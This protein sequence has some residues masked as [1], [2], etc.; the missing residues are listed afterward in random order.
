[1]AS[2]LRL[3][4]R[5][6]TPPV[7]PPPS[8]SISAAQLVLDTMA[9]QEQLAEVAS[10]SRTAQKLSLTDG[11]HCHGIDDRI[12]CLNEFAD[13]LLMLQQHRGQWIE[14]LNR[15]RESEHM[16]MEHQYHQDFVG[17]F[18]RIQQQVPILQQNLDAMAWSDE[19]LA[20]PA[21][22]EQIKT[23]LDELSVLTQQQTDIADASERLQSNLIHVLQHPSK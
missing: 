3:R 1:M 14:R 17:L 13:Q 8:E 10:Q 22:L 9:L 19:F 5:T 7:P 16:M 20:S 6:S 18:H 11:I 15:P 12:R 4:D 21:E 2:D 23:S